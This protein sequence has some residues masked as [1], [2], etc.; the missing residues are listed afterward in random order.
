MDEAV[1][2]DLE[3]ELASP[4]RAKAHEDRSQQERVDVL[5]MNSYLIHALP[6]L[7]AEVRRLQAVERAAQRV[8][9]A[10]IYYG[11]GGLCAISEEVLRDDYAVERERD[12]AAL[13]V[14][15]KAW[16]ITRNNGTYGA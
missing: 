12:V 1:L 3:R 11:N 2:A 8:L 9:G 10:V 5:V 15:F 7:V 6:D 14:R 4:E 16:P 13:K